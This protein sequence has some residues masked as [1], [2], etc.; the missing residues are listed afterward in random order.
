MENGIRLIVDFSM[1]IVVLE[2]VLADL[3]SDLLSSGSIIVH[4]LQV[5]L[6]CV[7]VVY[8]EWRHSV[9]GVR[10]GFCANID[11]SRY[12]SAIDF[13]SRHICLSLRVYCYRP[14]ERNLTP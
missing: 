1:A 2:L 14:T 10:V 13:L 9:S 11:T 6:K 12:I 4:M 5:T 3:A 8:D 7:L